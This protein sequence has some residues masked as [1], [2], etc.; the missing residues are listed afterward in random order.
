MLYAMLAVCF[1]LLIVLVPAAGWSG[2]RIAQA[3]LRAERRRHGEEIE[4]LT[5]SHLDVLETSE[6]QRARDTHTFK[7]EIDRLKAANAALWERVNDFERQA[8]RGGG[9]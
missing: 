8:M 1:A 3:R 9:R 2:A 6:V 7:G 4:E 5:A